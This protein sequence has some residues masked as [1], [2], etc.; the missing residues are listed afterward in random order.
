MEDVFERNSLLN[1]NEKINKYKASLLWVNLSN[2]LKMEQFL[3]GNVPFSL[4]AKRYH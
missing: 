3:Q 4:K 2:T 1:P